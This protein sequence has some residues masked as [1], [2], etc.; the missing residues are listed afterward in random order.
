MTVVR[1]EELEAH[2]QKCYALCESCESRK[3]GLRKP[4]QDYLDGVIE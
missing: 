3:D 2:L 1:I 4:V